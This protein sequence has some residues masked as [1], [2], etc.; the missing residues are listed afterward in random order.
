MG[1]SA[2]TG[3]LFHLRPN[4]LWVWVRERIDFNHYDIHTEGAL[5]LSINC[6]NKSKKTVQLNLQCFSERI[7]SK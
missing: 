2:E 5:H 4:K 3:Q 6:D 7:D 1:T